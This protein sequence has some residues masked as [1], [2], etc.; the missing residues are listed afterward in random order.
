MIRIN[1]D[2]NVS[3]ANYRD[4]PK[5]AFLHTSMFYTIQGEGPYSGEPALFLR[6]AGCNIGAK[7]DCQWCDTK[8]DYDEGTLITFREV[9][10]EMAKHKTSLLVITG[11]EPLLQH[12][13]IKAFAERNS[14]LHIQ[15]ETNGMLLRQENYSHDLTYVVSPK[16]PHGK[17]TYSPLPEYLFG[18]VSFKFVMDAD[19]ASPYHTLPEQL[20]EDD[21]AKS[22]IFVSGITAY[23]GPPAPGVVQSL[24]ASNIDREK[25]ARNYAYAAA[26][27]MNHGFCWSLQS[28]LLAGVE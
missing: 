22:A 15:L 7:E 18:L 9:E 28:H 6:L 14:F 3:I 21:V 13:A 2:R 1:V 25:T 27:A 17:A 10:L 16:I 26:V 24:W 23:T 19:P 11:G 20:F 4:V 5:D 12:D 8:F